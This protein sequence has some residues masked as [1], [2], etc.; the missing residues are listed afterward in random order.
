MLGNSVFQSRP[1]KDVKDKIACIDY[2]NRCIYYGDMF[3]VIHRLEVNAEKDDL[4][5]ISNQNNEIFE[6]LSKSKIDSIKCVVPFDN[7]LLVLTE[8]TLHHLSSNKLQKSKDPLIIKNCSLFTLNEHRKYE[9]EVVVI[10]KKKEGILFKYDIKQ[11]RFI[12]SNNSFSVPEIPINIAWVEKCIFVAYSKKE[13]SLINSENF[14]VTTLSIP[15]G[16]SPYIKITDY[17]EILLAS[18]NNIGIYV[19]LDGQ[20]KQKTTISLSQKNIISMSTLGA[21]LLVLFENCIQVF[22]LIDS[23][24]LQEIPF[25]QTN[26]GKCISSSSNRIFYATTSDILFLYLTPYE[27]Q[28]EKCLFQGKVDDAFSIFNQHVPSSDP[29]HQ[30]KLEQLR[31]DSVWALLKDMQFNMAKNQ[32]MEINFDPRELILLFPDYIP[33]SKRLLFE[34]QKKY[35][36]MTMV[37]NESIKEKFSKKDESEKEYHKNIKL[38]KEF[39]RDVLENRRYYYLSS[40]P[41]LKELLTF[42]SSPNNFNGNKFG[43]ISVEELLE[44]IDF[45]LIK[46]YAEFFDK[47]KLKTFFTNNKIYCRDMQSELESSFL[48]FKNSGVLAKFYENFGRIKECL[49]LWKTLAK[50]TDQKSS[51]EACEETVKV[52]KDCTDKKLI[53]ESL[54]WLFIKNKNIGVKIFQFLNE[55][56]ITPDQMLNFLSEFEDPSLGS[57]LKEKYLEILVNEKKIEDERFHTSL[58]LYYI[59][60]LFKFRPKGTQIGN[61]VSSDSKISIYEKKFSDFLKNP[62]SKYRSSTILEKI[63]DSWLLLDEIYLYGKEG[64]HKKALNKLVKEKE[65]NMA[66]SYCAERT[67]DKLLTQLFEIYITLYKGLDITFTNNPDDIKVRDNY[68]LMKNTVNNF[69]KKYATHQELDPIFVLEYMPDK[70]MLQESGNEDGLHA[71]LSSILSHTLNQKRNMKVA[72]HMSEMDLVNIEYQLTKT[73]RANIKI[74]TEKNCSVCHRRIGDKV[75]VIYPNGVVAHHTCISNKAQSICPVTGQN[76]EKNYKD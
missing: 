45:S 53:F 49:E 36:T 72:K 46:I 31:S 62:N 8:G 51:D 26:P 17:D 23:K 19:G 66:E 25:V 75:F 39:L 2:H 42:I 14:Q 15:I 70:W 48:Q 27:K 61:V 3:G 9:G 44:L 37:L 54:K 7:I 16:P 1:V 65:F 10:T 4:E 24:L 28:I 30:K 60:I 50:S 43:P 73:K 12:Q 57:M 64:Q 58:A 33:T 38:S 6:R 18:V 76:F 21:Y 67:G 74:T 35:N 13:Y 32:L 11:A 22:N 55:N 34:N 5:I 29:D 52:L 71:F 40:Y 56:L 47:D 41:N 59:D 20:M 63:K 68:L 69:L